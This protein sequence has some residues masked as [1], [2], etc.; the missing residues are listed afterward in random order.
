MPTLADYPFLQALQ[1]LARRKKV[2]VFLVGGFLRDSLLGRPCQDFDFTLK[3][4]AVPFCRLFARTIKGAFVLLDGQRGCGRVAKKH[5]G[6]IETYDFADFRAATLEKDLLHRDFTVNTLFVKMN[7]LPDDA[8]ILSRIRDPRGGLADLKAGR[9]RM[10]SARGFQDD[11]QRLLRAYSLQ[12]KFGLKIEKKTLIQIKKDKDLLRSVARERILDEFF[13]V[14]E[15]K[16]AAENLRAMD[17]IG[18]LENII[19]QI[20][21][22][23]GVTQGGYHHLDVW[24]HSLEVVA[25]LERVFSEY[26]ND[27]EIVQYLDEPIA[28]SRTRRGLLK[29]GALL[30]DIGKP[31]TRKKEDG[32]MSFHGHEHVGRAIAR[33]IAKLLKLSSRERVILEDTVQWHLRPG[34]LSNFKNPSERSYFRYFRDTKDEGAAIALLSL[35]DQRSTRGPLTTEADQRHHENICRGLVKRFFEM[36]KQKPFIRLIDGNDLIKKLKLKPSPVF[37]KILK[38]VDEAQA[39][40]KVTNKT[41]AL[42]LAKKV[43]AKT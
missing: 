19:P 15:S 4:D 34:Y 23:Y 14:L 21:V 18:L 1:D 25:Q 17:R 3:K 16:R 10:V 32:R 9:V 26:E 11:P 31:Q 39:T 22:M 42:E 43:V 27:R 30:H 7:V 24:P 41:E 2:D 20:T 13:K 37:G 8:E 33:P 36:K 35:A 5:D 40:G 28:G 29:L 12:A 38:A 6:I